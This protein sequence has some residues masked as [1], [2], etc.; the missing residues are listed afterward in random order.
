MKRFLI[1]ASA[2]A[3][4]AA[5]CGG[6]RGEVTEG[7]GSDADPNPSSTRLT[8]G[9]TVDVTMTDFAFSPSTFTAK[10]GSTVTFRF[11]NEGAVGHEG[12]IQD[13]EGIAGHMQEMEEGEMGEEHAMEMPGEKAYEVEVEPGETGILE[14]TFDHPGE[15]I[16]GCLYP[17]HHEAGM[18]GTIT[19]VA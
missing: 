1:A 13:E 10:A 12:V 9:G 7:S 11:V 8:D 15:L 5:G 14:Y 17:G 6:S 4:V 2:L 19:V 3:L 16:L 18:T